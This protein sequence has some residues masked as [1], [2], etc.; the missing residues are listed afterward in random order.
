MAH[1]KN[2]TGKINQKET[3]PAPEQSLAKTFDSRNII[4]PIILGILFLI[5][6][7]VIGVSVTPNN[8]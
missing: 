1:K 2:K 5:I 8:G 7:A 4:F 3:A 6:V